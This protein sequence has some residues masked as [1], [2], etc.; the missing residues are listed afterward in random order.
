MPLSAYNLLSL[1]ENIVTIGDKS[2]HDTRQV[3][4]PEEES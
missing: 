3:E 4:E 2:S 1:S